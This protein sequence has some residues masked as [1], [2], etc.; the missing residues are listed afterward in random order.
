MV[1]PLTV[2]IMTAL[3]GLMLTF[4]TDLTEQTEEYEKQRSKLYQLQE[5]EVV[6]LHDR[7]RDAGKEVS[8]Q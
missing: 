2:L 4:Y 8:K 1:L 3:I 7:L 5:T 6:R